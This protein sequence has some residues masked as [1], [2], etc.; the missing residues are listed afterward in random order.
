MGP[1]RGESAVTSY[2]RLFR[3]IVSVKKTVISCVSLLFVGCS[4]GLPVDKTG[5]A[6]CR[7]KG[8]VVFTGTVTL[9]GESLVDESELPSVWIFDN[10]GVRCELEF[11]DG[12]VMTN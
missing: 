1:G 4:L 12:D 11:R 8:A 7:S 2:D 3:K 6:V 9:T 5:N 10:D